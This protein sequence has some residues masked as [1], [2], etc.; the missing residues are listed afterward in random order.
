MDAVVMKP[1]GLRKVEHDKDRK[2]KA[3]KANMLVGCGEVAVWCDGKYVIVRFKRAFLLAAAGSD[4]E[5]GVAGYGVREGVDAVVNSIDEADLGAAQKSAADG[6]GDN[7]RAEL[8][9]MEGREEREA[10][11]ASDE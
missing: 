11:E 10:S 7:V 5:R 1:Q 3:Y 6:G 8:D 4:E 9:G 2:V